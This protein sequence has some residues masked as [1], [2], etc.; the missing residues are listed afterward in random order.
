MVDRS[1]D[2]AAFFSLP[3]EWLDEQRTSCQRRKFAQL[4]SRGYKT[5]EDKLEALWEEHL[6]RQSSESETDEE[7]GEPQQSCVHDIASNEIQ[8]SDKSN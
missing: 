5:R 6:I 2:K 3:H 1:V 7:P 4:T 8:D